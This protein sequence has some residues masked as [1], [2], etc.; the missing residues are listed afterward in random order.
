ML[1]LHTIHSPANLPLHNGRHQ[2][3]REQDPASGPLM[4]PRVPVQDARI[5]RAD[6][7]VALAPFGLQLQLV[8]CGLPFGIKN[9][10]KRERK[11]GTTFQ[12]G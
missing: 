10:D 8:L 7:G 4:T 9:P 1:Q 5:R 12:N 6:A 2:S 3:A 11:G